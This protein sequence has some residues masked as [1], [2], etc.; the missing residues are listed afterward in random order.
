MSGSSQ[1]REWGLDAVRLRA[2]LKACVSENTCVHVPLSVCKCGFTQGAHSLAVPR[3]VRE[4]QNLRAARVLSCK[5]V[6]DVT[7]THLDV[8]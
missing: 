5:L 8:V 6:Y 4:A 3:L 1:V 7:G 2:A